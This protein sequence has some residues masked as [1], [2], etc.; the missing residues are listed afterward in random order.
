M[1]P[2]PLGQLLGRGI[3]SRLQQWI[4]KCWVC[5]LVTPSCPTLCDPMR[6]SP[7]GSSVHGTLQARILE[8]VA[9]P[10]SRGSSWPG[11]RTQISCTAGRLFTIWATRE[12][13]KCWG[14]TLSLLSP[15]SEI[16]Q[17]ANED[18][19]REGPQS[20]HFRFLIPSIFLLYWLL[21]QAVVFPALL[22]WGRRVLH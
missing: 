8:W 15:S 18:T 1:G 3:G 21:S 2:Q 22:F 9:T 16:Y 7:P 19:T 14:R 6:C 17:W 11:D 4:P 5:M 13:P 10:F 12:A 20:A